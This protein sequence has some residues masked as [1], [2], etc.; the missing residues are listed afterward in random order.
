MAAARRNTKM[1]RQPRPRAA[2]DTRDRYLNPCRVYVGN[3]P[4]ACTNGKLKSFLSR[5]G[6]I[7][8][9]RIQVDRSSR[10]CDGSP[11]S[12]GYAFVLFRSAAS[13]KRALSASASQLLLQKRELT[14]HPMRP[15]RV[16]LGLKFNEYFQ[17]ERRP[18]QI[19]FDPVHHSEQV[20]TPLPQEMLSHIFQ[21]LPKSALLACGSVCRQWRR[22]CAVAWTKKKRLE[23]GKKYK[24]HCTPTCQVVSSTSTIPSLETLYCFLQRMPFLEELCID[25][26]NYLGKEDLIL[27]AKGCPHLRLLDVAQSQNTSLGWHTLAKNCPKLEELH[28]TEMWLEADFREVLGKCP[29]RKLILVKCQAAFCI[30]SCLPAPSLLEEVTLNMG[31]TLDSGDVKTLIC[32]SPELVSL[33]VQHWFGC[34]IPFLAQLGVSCPKLQ[35]LNLANTHRR[36]S[37][38]DLISSGPISKYLY[39]SSLPLLIDLDLT[40]LRELT[41]DILGAML[42]RTPNLRRLVL[43]GCK[44]LESGSMEAI[45]ACCPNIES[46]DLTCVIG[47]SAEALSRLAET[48]SGLQALGLRNCEGLEDSALVSVVHHCPKIKYLDISCCLCFSAN[49]LNTL[50]EQRLSD[51]PDA[52]KLV[53]DILKS[54]VDREG[55]S[56]STLKTIEC[57][58]RDTY[59]CYYSDYEIYGMALEMAGLRVEGHEFDND[60]NPDGHLDMELLG[61]LGIAEPDDDYDDPA[62]NPDEWLA[63]QLHLHGGVEFLDFEF[64][65]GYEEWV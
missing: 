3:V 30:F 62:F 9:C 17:A 59:P 20:Q 40:D 44:E 37:V 39:L 29:L 32:R 4:F 23:I 41:D 16:G 5:F 51:M 22:A 38:V 55:C 57:T 60:I 33:N 19:H 58:Y 1:A 14:I 21:Y 15:K 50:D 36:D 24:N 48:C 28:L 13:A 52:P 64:G 11:L 49:I 56:L 10:R 31:S 63:D 8:S 53:V 35:T 54:L 65:V 61:E 12:R 2:T 6:G 34:D 26:A 47:I 27:I 45:R 42:R 7:R 46:L 18:V 25:N 43:A